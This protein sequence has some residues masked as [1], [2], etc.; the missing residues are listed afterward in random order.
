MLKEEGGL[1]EGHFRCAEV[2]SG[3]VQ[4]ATKELLPD[5]KQ[6]RLLRKGMISVNSLTRLILL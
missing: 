4:A 3:S 1:S 6:T 5:L 2:S